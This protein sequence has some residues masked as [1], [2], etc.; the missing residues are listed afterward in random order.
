[1]KGIRIYT[2]AFFYPFPWKGK[3]TDDCISQETYAVHH[4]EHS[5]VANN[6]ASFFSR[7]RMLLGK[8]LPKK[9]YIY[10]KYGKT[11]IEIYRKKEVRNGPF[12]GMKYAQARSIG[13]SLLPKLIGSY[14]ECLH[15]AI[16]DLI[17]NDY[18]K[19]INIGCGEGYY[20]VGFAR[21]FPKTKVYA[22]D[23]NPKAI[24]LVNLNA[25]HNEVAE[26]VFAN[27]IIYDKVKLKEESFKEKTL[28][29]CDAEGHERDL[30]DKE[31]IPLLKNVDLII[32]I[33]DFIKPDTKTHLIDMFQNSH[34]INIVKQNTLP[35]AVLN[36][37]N[38]DPSLR[39]GL[40]LI[41]EN[42]PE[43]MEWALLK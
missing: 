15:H 18:K 17:N 21:L 40:R 28:V 1:L 24:Q 38:H 34:E 16:Y 9:I 32:E 2:E 39:K 43:I 20:S 36:L 26:R 10:Y 35:V 33:H 11:G 25:I 23:I 27:H 8:I 4:W 22:Y 31:V 41:D 7:V 42:R 37:F 3:F 5:W 30:F 29:F 12:K 19:I 6:Q 14:E 13:S